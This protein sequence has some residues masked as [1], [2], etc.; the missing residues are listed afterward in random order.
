MTLNLRL[1]QQT[2]LLEPVHFLPS[3]HQD[4]RPHDAHIDM[5]VIHGISLPP[6]QFN[7]PAVEQFFC[8]R[9]NT[10]SDPTLL[11]I[12]NLNV[13]SHLFIKRTGD[14][15]QFVPFNKRAW[16]AGESHFAGKTRCNDFSIGIEL[17]GTDDTPYE[18]VQYQRLAHVV[19]LLMQAY[20]A[21][22]PERI[23]GHE[24]IAPGRKTDPGPFF[25]WQHL[26]GLIV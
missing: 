6:G 23:V 24:H 20:A 2:H 17:E 7:T 26:K 5:I 10:S 21:I 3:P 22:V 15:I 4:E 13:S 16:H 19:Q 9:L 14:I 8:G 11:A 12:A 18:S 1:N 25:D